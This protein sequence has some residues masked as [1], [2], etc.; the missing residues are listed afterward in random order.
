[1]KIEQQHMINLKDIE[2]QLGE[3]PINFNI[4]ELND[5]AK[6]YQLYYAA[7]NEIG[8]KLE[9]LDLEFKINFDHNPIHHMEG[10]LKSTQSL[11][12]KMSRKNF[13]LSMLSIK[14]N[15]FDVAG[16]RVITN[17]I[18]D[19][20]AVEKM[21]LKQTDIKL[22]KRKD[23]IAIPKISGYR[24]LHLIVSV[25]VFQSDG[26]FNTNVEIQIR[27]TGMDTWASL[28]HDLRYKATELNGP[29]ENYKD[30]LIDY[31]KQLFEI[32]TN[33]QK[34]HKVVL[35]TQQINDQNSKNNG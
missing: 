33:F 6:M 16:V 24:S 29:I 4:K 25:P 26:V 14:K 8:T 31:S 7:A 23:Y 1:M 28:E 34:I 21:L 19:V 18:D 11:A 12:K 5:F 9:N 22:V 2:K 35:N 3:V 17:Y 13:E 32:E 10:R 30:S 15:I 27:T 20:Y